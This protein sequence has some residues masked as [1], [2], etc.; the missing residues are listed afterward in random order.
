MAPQAICA[1]RQ[2]QLAH[3]R[4]FRS[5]DLD[6]LLADEI[7]EWRRELDWDYSRSA[8]VVR[9]LADAASLGGVALTDGGEVVG[10][11][12]CGVVDGKAQIWNVYVRPRWRPSGLGTV[13]FNAL[14]EMLMETRSVHRIECQ[15][16]LDEIAPSNGFV[17][18]NFE[19]VLMRR[20][21]RTPLPEGKASAGRFRLERWAD[22]H[23]DAAAQVLALAHSGH[24][25]SEMS[26]QYRTFAGASRFIYDLV[27]FPGCA[28]FCREA[29]Y[30]AFD[31][32]TGHP[33]GI[34]LANFVADDVGHIGELCVIPEAQGLGLGYELL[35]QSM[36]AL[37][38]HGAERIS[39]TVTS[40]N[41]AALSL[42]SRCGFREIRRFHACVW[43]NALR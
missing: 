28:A 10:L 6:L 18:R 24:I 41:S 2:L 17:L 37:G 9:T 14:F 19:R 13:I 36:H 33:A 26:D 40:A 39:L 3:L 32:A 12:Y 30:V 22:R 7:A 34:A 21:A 42:Y 5:R 20:D 38:S 11:G 1:K 4:D 15:L 16:M 25:D 31:S 29:S 27:R 8:E 35:R 43:D 23:Q